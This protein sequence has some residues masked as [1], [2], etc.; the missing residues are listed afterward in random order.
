MDTWLSSMIA[1]G[2]VSIEKDDVA[3]F[4][5]TIT[6]IFDCPVA[7]GRAVSVS[8]GPFHWYGKVETDMVALLIRADLF[9]LDPYT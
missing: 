4:P 5:A 1:D 2:V 6:V 7:V 3:T 9:P 8:L